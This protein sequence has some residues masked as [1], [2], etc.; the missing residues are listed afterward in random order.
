MRSVLKNVLLFQELVKLRAEKAGL[1][2]YPTHSD[3][4]LDARMAKTKDTVKTFLTDMVGKMKEPLS[5]EFEGFLEMK[6]RE[7]K[8]NGEEFS[9]TVQPWDIYHYMQVSDNFSEVFF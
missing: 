3:F 8:E 5:A 1:L 6:E 9:G 4:I 7:C 2:G